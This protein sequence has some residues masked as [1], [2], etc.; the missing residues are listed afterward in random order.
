MRGNRIMQDVEIIG[1]IASRRWG[2][3]FYRVDGS[4]FAD[5]NF[6]VYTMSTRPGLSG[7]PV[8]IKRGD[9]YIIRAIHQ[10]DISDII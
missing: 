5:I 9:E 3:E 4:A 10:R 2:V 1:Y 7:S 8:L 6:L